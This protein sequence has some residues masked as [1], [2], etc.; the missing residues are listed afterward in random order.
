MPFHG[1]FCIHD[2]IA[3]VCAACAAVPPVLLR[4]RVWLATRR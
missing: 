3:M 2:I 1:D 4:V